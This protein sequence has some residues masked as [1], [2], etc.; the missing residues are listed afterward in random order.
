MKSFSEISRNRSSG[1]LSISSIRNL[2]PRSGAVKN[3]ISSGS[4]PKILRFNAENVPPEDVNVTVNESRSVVKESKRNVAHLETRQ[5]EEV[6][7]AADPHVKVI[8]RIRPP[9]SQEREDYTVRKVSDNSVAVGDRKFTV[10]AV[11]DSKSSQED[12]FQLVGVSMVKSA[13]AGYNTSMV[14][15]GQTGSGKSYTLWGPPGAMV[16]D[17]SA[18]GDL[19]IVPRIFQTLFAEIEREQEQTEGKQI[20]YQ[21]RCSFLEIYNEQIGDLLDPTQRNLEI[22]DDAK[23][24]FYVENLTEEY[25]TGFGDVTQILSKGLSNRKVGAT[26]I[27]TTSSRSHIVFTCVIESW[28]K[29]SKNLGSSRTSRITL[30]DL[31][32]SEKNR[33]N[34][35]GRECVKEGEF[36]KK[37]ISELGNLVNILAG[38]NRSGESKDIPYNNSCLTHLL[39]ESLGGNS[40]LTVICTISPDDKCSAET[41]STL[42]FGHRAKL[43]HNNPVVNKLTEDDVND[44][45]DQIR[46]LKEELIRAKTDPSYKNG[47]V[48]Q[49]LN[50]LTVSLNRSLIFPKFDTDLKEEVDVDEHDVKDLQLKFDMLHSSSDDEFQ[51]TSETRG[52]RFFS[53]GGCEGDVAGEQYASCQEDSENEETSSEEPETDAFDDPTLSESPKFGHVMQKSVVLCQDNAARESLKMFA[54]PTGSLAASLQRGMEIIDNHQR[55][56]VFNRSL[57]AL[58]F[59]HLATNTND[60]S[61]TKSKYICSNCQQRGSN[62][63]D[64]SFK[65]WVVGKHNPGNSNEVAAE[66]IKKVKDLETLCMQQAA[67]IEKLNDLVLQ[68]KQ[69]REGETSLLDELRN[70]NTSSYSQSKTFDDTEKESLLQEIKSLRTKLQSP[71]N[72]SIDMLRSSLHLRKTSTTHTEDFQTE[73]W[74]EMES[75]WICLTDELRADLEASRHHSEKLETELESEKKHTEELDDALMRSIDSHGKMVEHYADLQEKYTELEQKHRLILEGIAEVKRAAAKAGAKGHGKRFSKSLAAE[76]SVLR[77]EREKE[78]EMLK[79]ENRS[80]KIQLRDT[81][82]AVHAAGELLVRLREAEEAAAV[83]QENYANIQEESDKLKKKIEKQKRKHQLEMVTMKQYLAEDRLPE[84]ALRPFYREDSNV[85]ENDDVDDEAWRAEFGAIYQDHF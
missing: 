77:V 29:D 17:R 11:I 55:S 70:G 43:M 22:K 67:E 46:T 23:H 6:P 2:I 62:D 74:T 14:A 45:S 59:D 60:G 47:S 83:A 27:N 9:N 3:K 24:G 36:V 65:T 48:R 54:G 13:M 34:D 26:S 38:T 68:Y 63:V 53:T 21:C 4:N 75:E 20:N 81:V 76:L 79:K 30:V 5:H 8:A 25:V 37:S 15:Y 69:E 41:I 84:S 39:R 58:S 1:S 82:E 71:S 51:E 78:R 40:K 16:E 85:N 35:A 44:L 57:V 19:G 64:E 56:S 80:L 32:V 66:N 28:C 72:K 31:A 50:Q 73:R 49:S 42:R 52:T 61:T 12:V 33:I 10:D 18:S 7:F